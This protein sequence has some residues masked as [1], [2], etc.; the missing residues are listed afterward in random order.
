MALT[1]AVGKGVLGIGRRFE[2][3]ASCGKHMVSIEEPPVGCPQCNA[4]RPG[5]AALFGELD[6]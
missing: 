2:V 4:E 3:S 1:L 6:P 5:V